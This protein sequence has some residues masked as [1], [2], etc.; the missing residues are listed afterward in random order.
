MQDLSSQ[1]QHAQFLIFNQNKIQLEIEVLNEMN[2]YRQ[3]Y[4]FR[5]KNHYRMQLLLPSLHGRTG[6]TKLDH[7]VRS[8]LS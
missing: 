3:N 8:I 2:F 1:L 4:D 7:M 6:I 5:N